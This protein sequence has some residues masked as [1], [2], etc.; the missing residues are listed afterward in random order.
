MVQYILQVGIEKQVLRVAGRGPAMS[1]AVYLVP[2]YLTLYKTM[3][4]QGASDANTLLQY[5]TCFVSGDE[6]AWE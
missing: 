1:L 6:C 2:S 4:Y 3:K 5:D